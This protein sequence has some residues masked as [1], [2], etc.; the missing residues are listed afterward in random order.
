MRTRL[1]FLESA[2]T[3]V[4]VKTT[5]PRSWW[6]PSAVWRV[7]G[8]RNSCQSRCH[9]YEYGLAI[10][11]PLRFALPEANLSS[12]VLAQIDNI[13]PGSD[14]RRCSRLPGGGETAPCST[15]LRLLHLR[16]EPTRNQQRSDLASV[17]KVATASLRSRDV[18]Q[19]QSRLVPGEK[20][21]FLPVG[22][23]TSAT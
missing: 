8:L 7:A 22:R 23:I 16:P 11:S 18:P 4:C 3:L 12:R 5:T 2:R 19:D 1:K 14:L 10:G 9:G 17:T 21:I 20:G 6:L 15:R 13:A